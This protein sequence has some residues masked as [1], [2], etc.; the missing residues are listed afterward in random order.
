MQFSVSAT[1]AEEMRAEV[2]D[3]VKRLRDQRE[4]VGKMDAT[5]S[6]AE[7]TGAVCGSYEALLKILEN[8]RIE[9][10]TAEKDS[11]TQWAL[12]HTP[13]PWI[14]TKHGQGT[15]AGVERTQFVVTGAYGVIVYQVA[16][17][18][19]EAD[20]RLIGSAPD[21][22]QACIEQH[23][24]IDTLFAHCIAFDRGFLP[25]KTGRPWQALLQGNAAIAK[26]TKTAK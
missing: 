10:K 6:A 8:L 3:L 7:R 1:T 26:A 15:N 11:G 4:L 16:G 25:T 24:A 21:L 5:Q 2:I 23:D 17:I 12:Q 20:A 19:A 22:L 18:N 9:P 13:G 14:V